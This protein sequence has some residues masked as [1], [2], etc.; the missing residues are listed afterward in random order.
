MSRTVNIATSASVAFLAGF[1]I[2]VASSP[3]SAQDAPKRGGTLVYALTADPPH[4]NAALTN[5]LNA[6]QTATQVFSQLIR[7]NKNAVAAE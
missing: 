5:D 3:V 2:S 1:L 7:V 4:L 6:Q